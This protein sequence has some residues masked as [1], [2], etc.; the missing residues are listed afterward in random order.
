MRRAK[1]ESTVLVGRSCLGRTY[2]HVRGYHPLYAVIAGTGDVVHCRLRGGNAH[3]GRGGAGFVTETF[4][5][6]R[7]AGATGALTLRADSGFYSGAI[8]AA[9]FEFDGRGGAVGDERVVGV[10]DEQRELRSGG[11]FDA[12]QRTRQ[13][14]RHQVRRACPHV[15]DRRNVPSVDGARRPC[16]ST[17]PVAPARNA[18]QSSIE[19]PPA[20]TE[21]MI[22]N[23]FN[24]TFACPGASPR[25]T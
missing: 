4:N 8:T 18:S 6:F 19:S 23:A 10:V 1:P 3:T 12:A 15:K 9:C 16:P 2:T 11:G 21:S 14:R 20:R 25:S 17:T 24:P 13:A 7:A 5:R 22:V